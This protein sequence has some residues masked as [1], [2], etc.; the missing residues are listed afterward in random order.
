MKRVLLIGGSGRLGTSIRR[1]WRD[2]EIVAPA[3]GELDLSDAGALAREVARIRADVLINCAAFHDVDRCET[4]PVPA[5]LTNAI[6]VAGAA[7]VARDA[8]AAFV[9]VSTDYV[10]D[11]AADSPYTEN[12]APH[13]LSVYGTSK[14][15]GEY[16]VESLGGRAFVV[17]TCGVYGPAESESRRPGLVERVLASGEGGPLRVVGDVYA[18]PTFAGDLADAL[19]RL[20]ETSAYGLYHAVNAGPVSWYDFAAE[21]ARLARV[22][23][24]IE[25]IRA[26]ERTSAAPR[27]RFSAL[28]SAKLA[29][30]GIPMPSWREGLAAYLGV[31]RTFG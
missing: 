25:P 10:F 3:H 4:E 22:D 14:L 31:S 27:P 24:A 5:F 9:T 6:A 2:C 11:G 16:L 15:A 23:A 21:T 13:P 28:S 19:R 29:A 20:I 26:R 8:G 30:L 1:R 12:D 18:S 17:R 7:R